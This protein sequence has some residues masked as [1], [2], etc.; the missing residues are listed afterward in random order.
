MDEISPQ[1][2][3]KLII[4]IFECV[5]NTEDGSTPQLTQYSDEVLVLDFPNDKRFRIEIKDLTRFQ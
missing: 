4:E 5:E 2:L 3:M 1:D